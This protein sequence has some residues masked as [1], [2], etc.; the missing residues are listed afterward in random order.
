MEVVMFSIYLSIWIVYLIL[1]YYFYPRNPNGNDSWMY[2][3]YLFLSNILLFGGFLLI[4]FYSPLKKKYDDEIESDKENYLKYKEDVETIY[5]DQLK[6]TWVTATNS[7][8]VYFVIGFMILLFFPFLY[9]LVYLISNS[10]PYI[11]VVIEN[12]WSILFTISN[13]IIFVSTIVWM[14]LFGFNIWILLLGILPAI[15]IIFKII[16]FILN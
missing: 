3:G 9:Y 12:V 4:M 7:K 13:F 6:D 11:A 5:A 2:Y 14:I 10:Y 15:Y 1:Y 8:N 16:R